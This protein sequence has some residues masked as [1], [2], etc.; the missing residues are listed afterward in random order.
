M[1]YSQ[2]NVFRP[3]EDIVLTAEPFFLHFRYRQL[4]IAL[5]LAVGELRV[6]LQAIIGYNYNVAIFGLEDSGF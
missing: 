6:P 4:L 3:L 1:L 2:Q 5:Y